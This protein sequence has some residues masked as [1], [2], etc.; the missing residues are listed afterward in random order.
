MAFFIGFI[1]IGFIDLQ[2][3]QLVSTTRNRKD[4]IIYFHKKPFPI[5]DFCLTRPSQLG[6]LNYI[7]FLRVKMVYKPAAY[8]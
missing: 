8:K 4:N 1:G 3:R 2:A 7:D 5:N 6:K